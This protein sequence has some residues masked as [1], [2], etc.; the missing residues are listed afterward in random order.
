MTATHDA[1]RHSGGSLER[2]GCRGECRAHPVL[3]QQREHTRRRLVDAVGIVAFVAEVAHRLLQDD[4][5]FIDR[6]WTAIA[7]LD[8]ELRA[9]LDIDDQRQRELCAA[10][11][12]PRWSD[13]IRHQ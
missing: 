10:R 12:R 7:I 3:R 9:F 1:A 8:V 2:D 4:A 5:E 6:L 13:R 11:P